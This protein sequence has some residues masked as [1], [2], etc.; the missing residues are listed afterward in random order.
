MKEE[1]I[2]RFKARKSGVWNDRKFLADIRKKFG[3]EY[4]KVIKVVELKKL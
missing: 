1:F 2:G 4:K 3:G